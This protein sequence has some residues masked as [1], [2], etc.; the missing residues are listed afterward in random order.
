MDVGQ[1]RKRTKLDKTFEIDI[2]GQIKNEK[3]LDSK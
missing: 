3:S 2:I 1:N